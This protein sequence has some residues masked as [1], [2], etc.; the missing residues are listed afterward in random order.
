MRLDVRHAQVGGGAAN[1]RATMG[2]LENVRDRAGGN[3][4]RRPFVRRTAA[5]L[6]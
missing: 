1:D 5:A 2:L 3:R 4:V 6:A